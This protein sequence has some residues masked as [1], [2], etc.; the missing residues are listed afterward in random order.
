MSFYE[1]LQDHVG[2]TVTIYTTSGGLSGRG[3]TGVLLLVNNCF[4]RIISRCGSTLGP[5]ADIPYDKIACF[6]HSAP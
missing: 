5:L 3:F 6:V 2:E 4:V 1:Q